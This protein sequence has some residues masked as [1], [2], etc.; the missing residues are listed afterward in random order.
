MSP[1]ILNDNLS[2]GVT[3]YNLHNPVIFNMRKVYLV[4]NGTEIL[5]HLGSKIWILAPQEM[6]QSSSLGNFKSKIKE[7]TPTNCPYRLCKNDQHQGLIWT[8]LRSQVWQ[9]FVLLS[10]TFLTSKLRNILILFS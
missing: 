10:Y 5:P 1:A 8:H 4:Y 6:R 7:W 3:P 2:S 9:L